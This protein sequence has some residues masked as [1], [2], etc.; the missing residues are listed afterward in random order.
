M[1][2]ART[3]DFLKLYAGSCSDKQI[4]YFNAYL[5]CNIKAQEKTGTN[6]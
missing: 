6:G 5:Y 2:Y 4:F 1:R 3:S